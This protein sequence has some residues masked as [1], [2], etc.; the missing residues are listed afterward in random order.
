METKKCIKCEGTKFVHEF[1]WKD[2]KNNKRQ[3]RCKMCYRSHR[4]EWYQEHKE[5]ELKTIKARTKRYRKEVKQWIENYK[6]SHPCAH[7]GEARPPVLQFHHLNP[8]E[9]D[10]NIAMAARHGWSMV[11]LEKEIAKCVVLCANC[12]MIEHHNTKAK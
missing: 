11:R 2:K 1:S 7:C 12:H 3:A 10:I 4:N 8:K 6:K 9:K 5:S